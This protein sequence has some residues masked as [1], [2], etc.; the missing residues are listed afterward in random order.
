MEKR[1]IAIYCRVATSEQYGECDI[2]LDIQ[3][4]KLRAY[5][6]GKGYEIVTVIREIGR[7]VT[8]KRPGINQIREAVDRGGIEMVL[9]T[10]ADRFGR[11]SAHK[12]AKFVDL[13]ATKGVTATTMLA[14]DLR[15]KPPIIKITQ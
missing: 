14:G 5:A 4:R 3:E 13:L 15:D 12:L 11:C 7:G 8:M 9:A 2:A 1:R 6:T 10:N